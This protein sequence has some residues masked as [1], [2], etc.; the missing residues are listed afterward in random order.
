MPKGYPRIDVRAFHGLC[1]YYRKFVPEFSEIAAPL[2][3]LTR[4]K[5]RFLWDEARQESIE[6]CC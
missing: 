1:S 5:R 4:R 2:H 6:R 3:F